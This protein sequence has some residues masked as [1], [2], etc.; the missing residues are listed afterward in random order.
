MTQKE[1][2]NTTTNGMLELFQ[3]LG[4]FSVTD[5]LGLWGAFLSTG[6]A[7]LKFSEWWRARPRLEISF[8]TTGC[9][10][11]GNTIWIRNLNNRQILVTYWEV[12]CARKPTDKVA[13][14][15]VLS[16]HPDD[17]DLAIAPD[18]S[19]SIKFSKMDFFVITDDFLRGRSIYLL[20]NIAGRK[21]LTKKIY[22]K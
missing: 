14:S 8:D 17:D 2:L 9:E 15:I 10:N 3:S 6:L 5:V 7:Y 21:S 4:S 20:L 12:Y 16:S 19:G 13:R 18:S 11:H 22:P 1:S